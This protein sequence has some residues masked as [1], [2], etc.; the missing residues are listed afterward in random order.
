MSLPPRPSVEQLK[1]KA[2][3]LLKS[4]KNGD[5]GACDAF[6]LID[7]YAKLTP[8]RILQTPMSLRDAQFAIALSYGFTGWRDLTEYVEA[9]GAGAMVNLTTRK[10]LKSTSD[11]MPLKTVPGIVKRLSQ[12][13]RKELPLL[14]SEEDKVELFSSLSGE[15]KQA[16]CADDMSPEVFASWFAIYLHRDTRL[17]AF[18]RHNTART[19][20]QNVV[21]WP[22]GQP[23]CAM[24][25]T[26]EG[27]LASK[28]AFESLVEQHLAEGGRTEAIR[29]VRIRTGMSLKEASEWVEDYIDRSRQ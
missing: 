12:M 1:K 24:G 13:P 29:I 7:R 17:V 18:F 26:R 14:L 20:G 28:E 11:V 19:S 15:V 8:Q 10:P 22:D 2:K 6:M 16:F 27:D 4:H 5:L 23:Y 9:I 21:F 25:Q 3:D